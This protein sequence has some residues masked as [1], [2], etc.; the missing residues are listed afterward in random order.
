VRRFSLLFAIALLSRAQVL[1]TDD[2]SRILFT[3]ASRI[4][5]TDQSFRSKLFSWDGAEGIR[6]VYE[7]EGEVGLISASGDGSLA[8]IRVVCGSCEVKERSYVLHTA[9]RTLEPLTKPADWCG[10]GL[11]K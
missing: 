6:L 7:A 1:T 11:P 9:T 4:A 2:G 5:G 8:T 3:T 10:L